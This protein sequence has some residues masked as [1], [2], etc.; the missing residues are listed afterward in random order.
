MQPQPDPSGAFHGQELV[1]GNQRGDHRRC[2]PFLAV[3]LSGCSKDGKTEVTYKDHPFY[4]FQGDTKAGDTTGQELDQF[5]A[6]WY[7]LSTTGNKI[8]GKG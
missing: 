8:E 6:E 3:T 5:G 1:S 4:Y 7:V 2:L